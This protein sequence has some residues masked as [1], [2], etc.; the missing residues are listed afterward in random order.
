[1][2][3]FQVQHSYTIEVRIMNGKST[4]CPFSFICLASL[5]GAVFFLEAD[6]EVDFLTDDISQSYFLLRIDIRLIYKLEGNSYI[7]ILLSNDYQ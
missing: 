6:L 5:T 3:P 4:L 1:M 2:K 7:Y